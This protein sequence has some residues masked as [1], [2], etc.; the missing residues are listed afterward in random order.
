MPTPIKNE[1]KACDAVARILEARTGLVRTHARNPEEDGVGPPVDYRFDLGSQNYALEHTTIEAFK[2][3]IQT[4][5]DFIAF[6]EPIEKALSTNMPSPGTYHLA[7]PIDPSAKVKRKDH[8]KVQAAIIKWAKTN[9]EKPYAEAPIK[10]DKHHMPHGHRGN[11]RETPPGVPFELRL[12]REVHWAIPV[13]GDGRLFVQRIAPNDVE[14]S[15]LDRIRTALSKKL[16][17]LADTKSEGALLVLV[18]ETNDIALTNHVVVTDAIV[19][20]LS[21]HKIM[22][23]E[24]FLVDTTIEKE[25]TV[26]SVIRGDQVWPDEETT[27]RYR[28]F[29]PEQLTQV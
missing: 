28:D 15:R 22:Q 7:F 2:G 5:V 20:A 6:V 8:P 14:K 17:K 23:D 25:W 27:V 16:P 10:K 12:D 11:I 26:W 18:F 1:R 29:N 3:Q 19:A 13:I 9:A 21:E 24:I 4:G